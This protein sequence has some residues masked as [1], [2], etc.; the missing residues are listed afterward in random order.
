VPYLD[1]VGELKTKPTQH[2]VK[3][4]RSLGIQPDIIV[5]RAQVPLGT[6]LKEKV[7]LFCN[8]NKDSV[9]ENVDSKLLYEVP[10]QLHEQN[11]DGLVCQKLGITCG[12]PNLSEWY[13][14][15]EK[16]RTPKQKLKVALVGTYCELR[17]AYLSSS[18]A[19]MHAGIENDAKVEIDWIQT[20]NIDT[21]EK[22]HAAL[23]KADAVFLPG[24]YDETCEIG[25][26]NA[27][28]Y[29]RENCVPLLATGGG[30]C[31]CASEFMQN[32]LKT[33][34]PLFE[35][36]YIMPK[37]GSAEIKLSDGSL[38]M[39]CYRADTVYERHRHSDVLC[40]QA[41]RSLEAKGLRQAA[42]SNGNTEGLELVGHPFFIAVQ[43]HPEFSSRPNNAHRLF[44]KFISAALGN[45]AK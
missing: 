32:V 30:F 17:D 5:C 11:L 37:L 31:F 38:L 41:A 45:R 12:E 44:A 34:M 23:S 36:K 16:Y 27:V 8:V 2:S 20:K 43:Y 42:L 39:D 10:V 26:I 25:H 22:T 14:M 21:M 29:A 35:T 19:L 33:D 3:E 13:A 28:R 24:A 9:V 4:L 7:A 1:K 15:L 40:D 18:E 6:Q